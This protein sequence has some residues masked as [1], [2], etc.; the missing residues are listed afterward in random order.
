MGKANQWREMRYWRRML[1]W[2]SKN[3]LAQ[4]P[5]KFLKDKPLPLLTETMRKVNKNVPNFP[6]P[7]WI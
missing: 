7:Q 5:E 1:A 2:L 3:P 4:L 6:Q